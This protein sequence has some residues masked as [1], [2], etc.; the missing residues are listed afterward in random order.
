M[1]QI[2]QVQCDC[3]GTTCSEGRSMEVK[4]PII[5]QHTNHESLTTM[6]LDMCES[7]ANKF[8]QLYYKIAKEHNRSGFMAIAV[9]E[10]E[11]ET[12]DEK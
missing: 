11:E 12:E 3:C 2:V 8:V 6:E 10:E 5:M 7:C 4:I 9:E 1:S